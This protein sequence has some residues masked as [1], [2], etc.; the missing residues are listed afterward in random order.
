MAKGYIIIDRTLGEHNKSSFFQTKNLATS[1][2]MRQFR[3]MKSAVDRYNNK[4]HITQSDTNV[5]QL[6]YF[7]Y[8]SND[9]EGILEI[10]EIN[11]N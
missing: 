5:M 3:G 2:L 11:I 9:I 10:E 6:G 1:D 7:F 8:I 4:N